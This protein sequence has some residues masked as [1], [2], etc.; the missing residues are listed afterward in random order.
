VFVAVLALVALVSLP[1]MPAGRRP[2]ARQENPWAAL[3]GALADRP[4]AALLG[5][6]ALNGI[7]AAVPA[8]TVLFFV[9]D[10]V[11]REDLSG[12]FLAS[13]FSPAPQPARCGW[14]VPALGKR[15]PGWPAWGWRGG[16]C[17]GRLLGPGDTWPLG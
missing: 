2:M 7:A 12:L 5:V 9:A 10:V 13:T 8:S 14:P 17:L 1:G 15:G 11:R 16:V 3:R 6:F 4:F